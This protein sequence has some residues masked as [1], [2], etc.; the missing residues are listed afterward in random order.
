[1][2]GEGP[3][4]EPN[5]QPEAWPKVGA[6]HYVTLLLEIY[7]KSKEQ[8]IGI[9]QILR[10][11][12]TLPLLAGQQGNQNNAATCWLVLLI[13]AVTVRTWLANV[14]PHSVPSPDAHVSSDWQFASGQ[15]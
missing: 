14:L 1:M 7:T 2:A 3:L 8:K 15:R 9:W 10:R 13:Q 12:C 4:R 5:I 11:L 6:I